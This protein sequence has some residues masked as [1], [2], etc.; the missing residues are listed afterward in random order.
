MIRTSLLG[1]IVFTAGITIG[2]YLFSDTQPRPFL[3][4]ANCATECLQANEILGLLASVGIQKLADPLPFVLKETDKTLAI[5]HPFPRADIHYVII[6][7][8]D[9]KDAEDL[10]DQDAPYIMDAYAV[11][12]TLIREHGLRDYKIILNGPGFQTVRYLHFHLVAELPD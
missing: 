2:G 9:I 11:M 6:P 8:E 12:A 10:S 3:T 1:D 4:I 7:K 5:E